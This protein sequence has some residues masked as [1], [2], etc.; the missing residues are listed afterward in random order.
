MQELERIPDN[1]QVS[2]LGKGVVGGTY[3]FN[4]RTHE[5]YF[6][7]VMCNMPGSLSVVVLKQKR[8]LLLS[9]SGTVGEASCH[10]NYSG[11]L[12]VNI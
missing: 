9:L 6:S 3:N 11:S 12:E 2:L 8:M 5:F 4:H 1:A 7:F 10:G